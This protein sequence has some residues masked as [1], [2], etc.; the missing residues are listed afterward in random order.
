MDLSLKKKSDGVLI[1][2]LK[3]LVAEERETLTK[4]LHH[5]R[6]IEIRKLYLAKGF[7]SLFVFLTEYIG[8]SESSAQRRIQAM[9]LIK[10]IPE[11]EE[12]IQLGKISLSVAAQM[13]SFFR[14]EDQNRTRQ[15][16]PKLEQ[17]EKLKLVQTLQ[18]S[19]A[20]QCEQELAKIAPASV[21]PKEKARPINEEKVLLQLTVDKK[22]LEKINQ[23][24]GLLS[25]QNPEGSLEKLLEA[26]VELGLEKHAPERREAR[27]QKRQA[28]LAGESCQAA[29]TEEGE[30]RH[31]QSDPETRR[32]YKPLPTSK[33][34]MVS[35]DPKF[36]G[37]YKR[38][39]PQAVRDQ[40]WLRD[41][42]CCQHRDPQSKKICGSKH[43][44]QIDH[45]YPYSLGGENQPE[46]LR[47]LCAN[48]NRFHAQQSL[49][50]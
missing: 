37:Q 15:K 24:R 3:G 16:A 23:L 31:D 7:S 14:K 42:G 12:K 44:V 33:V 10:D 30:A 35:K 4:I 43:L 32:M 48:H 19:S 47:L 21:L 1:A 38:H 6:E 5:L 22:L 13:Q 46:N 50:K 20:R 28:K 18:G 36:K 27:R 11:V 29:A 2:D 41:Q 25:H 45:R 17:N 9:R 40:V 34:L 39:I 8:Y 49:Q 26:L